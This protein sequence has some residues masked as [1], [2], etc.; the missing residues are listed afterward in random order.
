MLSAS[1]ALEQR[2]SPPPSQR[3]DPRI[4][5]LAVREPVW[6]NPAS[7]L[8]VPLIE[9]SSQP[10]HR[11]L[12]GPGETALLAEQP[13][14]VSLGDHPGAEGLEEQ[15]ASGHQDVTELLHPDGS[16]GPS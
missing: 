11:R 9:Q 15:L 5:P 16:A 4:Q 10:L 1:G 14:D 2:G 13:I 3:F 12:L 8:D 6:R 7:Q